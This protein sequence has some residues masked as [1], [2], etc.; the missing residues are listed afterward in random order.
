[1]PATKASTQAPPQT[2]PGS[3]AITVSPSSLR[4]WEGNASRTCHGPAPKDQA[5]DG[6]TGVSNDCFWPKADSRPPSASSAP[7]SDRFRLKADI[8]AFAASARSK[9][10]EAPPTTT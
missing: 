2:E 6:I 7:L 8:L 9:K 1:M 4:L 5:F 10:L 3:L